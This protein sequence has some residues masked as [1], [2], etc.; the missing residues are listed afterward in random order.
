MAEVRDV[1]LGVDRTATAAVSSSQEMVVGGGVA[2]IIDENMNQPANQLGS[3]FSIHSAPVFDLNGGAIAG[4]PSP[5]R[6]AS[7]AV[8]AT[9]TSTPIV[10]PHLQSPEGTV[11]DDDDNDNL[12]TIS[13]LTARPL[14]AKSRELRSVTMS[15]MPCDVCRMHTDLFVPPPSR[16]VARTVVD[17]CYP[18]PVLLS[19]VMVS[20]GKRACHWTGIHVYRGSLQIIV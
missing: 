2:A 14:I 13:S 15:A 9:A 17:R 11:N 20:G 18:R 7:L 16:S 1:D 5:K 8:Q 10:P 6:P 3:L 4:A 12:L 19:F